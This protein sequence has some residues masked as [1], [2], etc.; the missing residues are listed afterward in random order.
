SGRS[1][2]Q[3]SPNG[4]LFG[5]TRSPLSG[6]RSPQSFE[7]CR[8][9][10]TSVASIQEL[11]LAS[12]SL[13][14]SYRAGTTG[15]RPT[16]HCLERLLKDLRHLLL[17]LLRGVLADRE[18]IDPAPSFLLLPVELLPPR[19]LPAACPLEIPLELFRRETVLRD[20]L[21][22]LIQVLHPEVCEDLG[23]SH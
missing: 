22:P 1:G 10:R 16:L 3:P 6:G 4:K 2:C 8:S 21:Q 19:K 5:M 23:V 15:L 17:P 20:L 7:E 14:E 13:V 12:T 18:G 11:H 9:V